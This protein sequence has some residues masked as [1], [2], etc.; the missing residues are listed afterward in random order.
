MD[1]DGTILTPEGRGLGG[2]SL[3]SPGTSSSNI[4]HVK[5]HTDGDTQK[6]GW[7]LEWT[8]VSSPTDLPDQCPEGWI[9][10]STGCYQFITTTMTWVNAMRQ[11][12]ARGGKL[13][14][15]G[16][17]RENAALVN[18]AAKLPDRMRFWIGLGHFD[19][20]GRWTW[21]AGRIRDDL[22]SFTDDLPYEDRVNLMTRD[23]DYEAWGPSAPDNE[24]GNE[25]CAHIYT[26]DWMGDWVGKWNDYRCGDSWC[27][28]ICE[29]LQ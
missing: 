11:C 15:I 28:A 25:N 22:P 2:S 3:P 21:Y 20:D 9:S 19:E 17:E 4:M 29:L 5:F 12:D 23:V 13:V 8:E 18:E 16:S 10:L 1:E 24:R 14:Q 26:G 7:R 27:G 6:T